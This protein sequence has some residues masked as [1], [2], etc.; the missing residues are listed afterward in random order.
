MS[1]NRLNNNQILDELRRS[2]CAKAG[3]RFISFFIDCIL[4]IIFSYCIFLGANSIA[5]TTDYYKN[6]NLIV[7]EEISY[8]NSYVAESRAVEFETI[9]GELSRTDEIYSEDGISKIVLENINRAIYYSYVKFGDFTDEYGLSISQEN[10]DLIKYSISDNGLEYDDNIS[11]FYATY[12]LNSTN[13]FEVS[14]N[15]KVEALEYVSDIYRQAFGD[16]AEEMFVFPV[17][18]GTPILRK[19][20][21]YY[22]YYFV[23]VA[24]DKKTT[25]KSE[26]YFYLFDTS[27]SN[28]LSVA[29]GLV[30]RSE[31]YYST[32]YKRYF[33]NNSNIGRITNIALI[34]SIALAYIIVIIVPKLIFKF[35]RTLGRLILKLGVLTT[36]DQKVPVYKN[37]IKYVCDFIG[38]LSIIFII[39]MLP[40]F[41]AS[42]SSLYMPFIGN[43]QLMVILLVI[44]LLVIINETISL[45]NTNKVSIVELLLKTVLK[46][47]NYKDD[48]FKKE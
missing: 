17:D 13:Q 37:I 20:A 8:Y 19:S 14:F 30:V 21:A 24:E 45:F 16:K 12:I 4:V 5:K 36:D 22:L 7:D 26:D 28:M 1:K 3:R 46:D 33:E 31:P 6:S 43:L 15:S 2:S 38:Y 47:R 40:P 23:Y 34:L 29:E 10:L 32:H 48:L 18:G 35:D 27:Y 39:Y 41:Y 11:Y 44:V 9:N 25:E 42:F